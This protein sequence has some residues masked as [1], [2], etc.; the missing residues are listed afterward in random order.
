MEKPFVRRGWAIA[1]LVL[2][3]ATVPVAFLGGATALASS[4]AGA[5]CLSRAL[6]RA[7]YPLLGIVGSFG[8]AIG[9]LYLAGAVLN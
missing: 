8:L 7:G 5:L 3:G 2:I 1:G 9:V 4:T 6:F